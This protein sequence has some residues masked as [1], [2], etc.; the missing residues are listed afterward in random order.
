MGLNIWDK[1]E[2]LEIVAVL[3]HLQILSQMLLDDVLR[4]LTKVFLSQ[5]VIPIQLA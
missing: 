5:D 1:T 3:L 4:L 2:K